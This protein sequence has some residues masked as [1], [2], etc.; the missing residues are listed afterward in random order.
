MYLDITQA[1]RLAH[2]DSLVKS[3]CGTQTRRYHILVLPPAVDTGF[4]SPPH[5]YVARRFVCPFKRSNLKLSTTRLYN[6]R[7][8]I[9]APDRY[10]QFSHLYHRGAVLAAG[11]LCANAGIILPSML[12]VA[13]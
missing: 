4:G 13:L 9:Q 12:L 2:D 3:V 5:S 11:V 8:R 1:R 10:S 7:A 6:S